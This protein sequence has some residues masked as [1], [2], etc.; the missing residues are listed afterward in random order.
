MRNMRQLNAP[1]GAETS[2][3]YYWQTFGQVEA[4]ELVLLQVMRIMHES[5][6][7]LGALTSPYRRYY[8][9][10][11]IAISIRDQKEVSAILKHLKIEYGDGK[12]GE[13]DGLTVEYPDWWFN[14]RP[15]NTEPILRLVVEAKENDL[16]EQKVAEIRE[17]LG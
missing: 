15:S 9:S 12:V 16:L 8:K 6:K 14:I 17:S 3:H 4:P 13:L 11:P 10:D 2:G 5:G 1:L 7:S